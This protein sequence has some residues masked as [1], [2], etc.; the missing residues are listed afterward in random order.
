MRYPHALAPAVLVR[1][2]KRFLAD[3]ELTDGSIVTAH[4]ANPGSML[5]LAE[6]GTRVLLSESDDPARK[7][8]HSWELA[9]AGRT[10][11][12]VHTARANAVAREAL[13]AGAIEELRGFERVVP[14]A[15][16]A[17]G[18]RFDFRLEGGAGRAWVEVKSVTMA[19]DGLALFPDAPTERGRRHLTE[20]AKAAR[21][22]ERAVMLYLVMREDCESFA[23]AARVDPEYAAAL[24]SAR[25]AGVEV[26]V[27]ACRVR[28]AGIGLAGPLPFA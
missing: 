14:E 6:I 19:E 13:E 15:A 2:Y 26:L 23:P 11:V 8:R 24:A 9:R 18:T 22:G 12:V 3:V 5:G 21:R 20:L 27:R 17:A 28:P 4:C 25:R 7:L 16:F 10:W 1:R